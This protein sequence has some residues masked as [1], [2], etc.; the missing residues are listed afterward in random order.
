M[1]KGI[2]RGPDG[3]N[4]GSKRGVFLIDFRLAVNFEKL[5]IVGKNVF[6][7]M[8]FSHNNFPTNFL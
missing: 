2:S 8:S 3:A 6:C 4:N 5:G 1:G 7:L